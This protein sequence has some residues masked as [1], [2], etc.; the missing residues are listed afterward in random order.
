LSAT[1]YSQAAGI[2]PVRH[3]RVR[4]SS[5]LIRSD[6]CPPCRCAGC[7]GEAQAAVSLTALGPSSRGCRNIV[8][9]SPEHPF[10]QQGRADPCFAEVFHWGASSTVFG[11]WALPALRALR[12][13]PITQIDPRVQLHLSASASRSSRVRRTDRPAS[14]GG[15]IT[16]R[17]IPPWNGDIGFPSSEP[18][19]PRRT[20]ELAGAEPTSAWVI[21][22]TRMSKPCPYG[23]PLPHQGG[24]LDPSG[25]FRAMPLP[26]EWSHRGPTSAVAPARKGVRSIRVSRWGIAARGMMPQNPWHDRHGTILARWRV[27]IRHS[28]TPTRI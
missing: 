2:S 19:D 26:K 16:W 9:L 28:P 17:W 14:S 11:N 18:F 15:S 7:E 4:C 20:S 24:G 13:G 12:A 3:P 6:R 21:R 22:C 8:P 25:C 23:Q 10:R 1:A 5:F 27:P